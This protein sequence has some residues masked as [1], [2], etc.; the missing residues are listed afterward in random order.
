MPGAARSMTDP[1]R[2][3]ITEIRINPR[4]VSFPGPSI[5][6]AITGCRIAD[7]I[8]ATAKSTPTSVLENPFASRYTAA[9]AW[10]VQKAAK[11]AMFSR[12]Y[13]IVQLM[14]TLAI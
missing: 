13:L 2:M 9:H 5:T 8:F 14:E 10:I 1:E 12:V 4:L 3:T 7:T 11:Y 6:E